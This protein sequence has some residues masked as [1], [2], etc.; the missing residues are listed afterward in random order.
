MKK[1]KLF[2][3]PEQLKQFN[4]TGKTVLNSEQLEK[5]KNNSIRPPKIKK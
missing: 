2:L 4:E 1:Q 3:T 5:F